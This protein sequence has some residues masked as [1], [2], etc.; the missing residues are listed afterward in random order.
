MS[1]TQRSVGLVACAAAFGFASASALAR[2]NDEAQARYESERAVCLHGQSNQARAT[3]LKEAGAALQD[4]RRGQLT[5]GSERDL[6]RNRLARC[7]AQHGADHDD[8]VKRM[9]GAGTTTGSA[10]S[11]GMLRESSRP[12]DK[13]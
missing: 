10:Q 3:C 5:T 1:T 12:D 8:C 2:P 4:A 7:D 9:Q 11:G 6:E 13:K